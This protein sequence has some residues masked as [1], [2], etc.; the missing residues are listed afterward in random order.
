MLL[1]LVRSVPA[2]IA[3]CELT[4]LERLPIDL[5][6]AARQHQQYVDALDALGC[7]VRKLP[8]L[9]HLPDSVF[10]ED[11]AVVLDEL[12]VITRP[13]AESR[14]DEISSVAE[15]L[16]EYRAL[17]FIE[18]PGTLDGGDVI[19]V[20]R[21]IFVGRSTRTNDEAIRQLG[22]IT[23]SLGYDVQA[24]SFRGC[25]HLKSAATKLADDTVL[26]N[27]QWVSGNAFAGMKTIE[28]DAEEPSA[29]NALEVGGSLLFPESYPRTLARLRAR[30]YDI[31]TVDAS[32]LAK[33]EGALT[34]CSLIVSV[35]SR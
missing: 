14:R 5:Q 8:E 28:I 20:S 10:V 19:V 4:H 17:R 23:S 11:A 15:A 9:P 27:P 7:I 13:G 33:A 3:Q 25:L 18:A 21:K 6:L 32:E 30:G 24:V 22:E 29:A 26:L 31:R 1:A 34:C 16:G 12:A 2:S 35:E